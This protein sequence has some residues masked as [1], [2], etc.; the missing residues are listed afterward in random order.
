[1]EVTMAI[2]YP[3]LAV[4]VGQKATYLMRLREYCRYLH[5]AVGLWYR[6]GLSE[7]EYDVGVSINRVGGPVSLSRV[8]LPNAIKNIMP[9]KPQISKEEF[10][11][12]IKNH[13]QPR[14]SR[15]E[16]EIQTRIMN[17]QYDVTYDS[18]IDLDVL[19]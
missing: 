14:F 2:K 12:F 10:D 4:T 13:W 9:Y 6:E 7:T 17:L 5:N 16:D 8:R 15:I 19:D 11:S 1:M 3:L 18:D